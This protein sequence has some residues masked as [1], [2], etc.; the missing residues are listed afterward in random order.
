MNTQPITVTEGLITIHKDGELWRVCHNGAHV[1]WFV[2]LAQAA[3][4]VAWLGGCER[5]CMDH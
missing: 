2:T 5:I 3:H 4:K 1:A